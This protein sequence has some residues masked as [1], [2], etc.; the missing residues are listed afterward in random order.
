MRWRFWNR[1]SFVPEPDVEELSHGHPAEAVAL[2][3]LESPHAFR[4]GRERILRGW[5]SY[6]SPESRAR[7]RITVGALHEPADL[8]RF[9]ADLLALHGNLQAEA[10]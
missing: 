5:L 1:S 3:T 8:E 10:G 6:D 7:L 2:E 4:M 9:G